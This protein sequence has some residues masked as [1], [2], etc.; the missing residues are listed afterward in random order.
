[1]ASKMRTSLYFVY[2]QMT[3]VDS[4]FSC[5]LGF[6]CES[7]RTNDCKIGRP[8]HGFPAG[9]KGT[10]RKISPNVYLLCR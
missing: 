9:I 10:V 8:I 5:R 6:E 2:A 1:M 7:G 4:V 3:S